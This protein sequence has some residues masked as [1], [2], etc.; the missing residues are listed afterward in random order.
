MLG[1]IGFFVDSPNVIDLHLVGNDLVTDDGLRTA[2]IISLFTDR[3]VDTEEVPEGDLSRRGWW[4]DL[5]S[6]NVGDQLGSRL[7]LLEREKRVQ[8][9]LNRAEDYAKESLDWLVDDGVADSVDVDAN[10]DEN[11]ALVLSISISRP[12]PKDVFKFQTKWQFEADQG[13]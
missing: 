8:E 12:K 5:F 10:Y 3:R 9:T 2:V 11:G 13:S 7:W 1:D 4:G 6:G